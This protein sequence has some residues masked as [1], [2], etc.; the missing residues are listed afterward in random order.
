[1]E[2][3]NSV[4]I[5]KAASRILLFTVGGI[6]LIF[7]DFLLRPLLPSFL[8]EVRNNFFQAS[9]FIS[10][11]D[12]IN[13]STKHVYFSFIAILVFVFVFSFIVKAFRK[14]KIFSGIEL[15]NLSFSAMAPAMGVLF[16]WASVSA[17]VRD[18]IPVDSIL[19]VSGTLSVAYGINSMFFK[20]S[21]NDE[22]ND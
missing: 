6:W 22:E 9:N 13:P 14:E 11:I 17:T 2:N 4:S 3:R 18:M 7:L 1:M 20:A 21:E 16:M 8:L 10:S 19:L 5:S 15:Y 12:I